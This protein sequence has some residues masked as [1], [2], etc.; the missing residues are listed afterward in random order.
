[1]PNTLRAARCIVFCNRSA[2]AVF[3]GET[4]QRNAFKLSLDITSI[5]VVGLKRATLCPLKALSLG[6]LREGAAWRRLA[7]V[8]PRQQGSST[9]SKP[10]PIINLPKSGN[11]SAFVMSCS[12]RTVASARFMRCVAQR[13]VRLIE[14]IH[15]WQIEQTVQV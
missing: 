13:C 1:M 11:P 7:L 15:C 3:V 8:A 9:H 4:H 5:I 14:Q 2:L 10:R 6:A 12:L